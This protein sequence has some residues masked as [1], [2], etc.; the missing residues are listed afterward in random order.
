VTALDE[1]RDYTEYA[2]SA[3]PW[4]RRFAYLLCQDWHRADDLVQTAAT[5]LYV[6]W[7]KASRVEHL[8]AYTRK[9][10]INVYL[11][12]QRTSWWKRVTPQRDPGEMPGAESDLDAAMDVRQ[13][14][15]QLPAKQRAAVVLRYYGGLSVDETAAVMGCSTTNVR[16]QTSRGLARLRPVLDPGRVTA[17]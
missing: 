13:A 10:L 2:A 4:L 5:Q 17:L 15:A 16:S 1:D 3:L 12:E 7:K 9:I 8:D 11:A 6:H 14:L